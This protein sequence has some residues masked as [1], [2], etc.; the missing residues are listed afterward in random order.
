M[1]SKKRKVDFNHSVCLAK[2]HQYYQSRFGNNAGRIRDNNQEIDN[3][4]CLAFSCLYLFM[5]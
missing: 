4:T 5:T 1:S 3:D 2:H